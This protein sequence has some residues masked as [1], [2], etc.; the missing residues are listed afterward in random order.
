[1]KTFSLEEL[2]RGRK[3]GGGKAGRKVRFE[4]LDRLARIGQGLSAAQKNDFVWWKHNWDARLLEEHGAKDW[5]GVFAELAQRVIT[6]L[7]DGIGNAFSV[8]V[9]AETRRCFDGA[10]VLQVP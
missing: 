9:H 8:F 7:E 5:P 1:M 3:L 6:D 2:G 10:P 4:V